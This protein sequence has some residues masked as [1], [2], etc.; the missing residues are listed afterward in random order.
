[1]PFTKIDFCA[2]RIQTISR[3]F[4]ARQYVWGYHGLARST[5]ASRLVQRCIRG[6]RIRWQL[7]I[8]R[9]A[10]IKLQRMWKNHKLARLIQKQHNEYKRKLKR[11]TAYFKNSTILRIIASWKH[12]ILT[13]KKAQHFLKKVL[14]GLLGST[15]LRWVE[16]TATRRDIRRKN[17]NDA[18]EAFRKAKFFLRR[19]A[20][21]MQPVLNQWHNVVERNKKMR[22][23]LKRVMHGELKTHYLA[24]LEYHEKMIKCRLLRK[25]IFAHIYERYITKWEVY[26]FQNQACK[27]IQAAYRKYWNNCRVVV[28]ERWQQYREDCAQKIQNAIRKFLAWLE[29]WGPSG[30]FARAKSSIRIQTWFRC[31]NTMRKYQLYKYKV[32]L[33]Q[34]RCQYWFRRRVTAAIF[35]QCVWRKHNKWEKKKLWATLK[36]QRVF[37]TY[38]AFNIFTDAKRFFIKHTYHNG[39]ACR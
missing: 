8:K 34:M 13:Q 19:L 32:I 4:L 16:F 24:W 30:L 28:D 20:Y 2:L 31:F 5:W 11:A 23:L 12:L 22:K 35:I 25:K 17:S 7:R 39:K 9:R 38:C 10:A 29:V 15:F 33:T 27:I 6:H 36:V 3:G 1:M 26:V 21:A 37:R 18:K 14:S